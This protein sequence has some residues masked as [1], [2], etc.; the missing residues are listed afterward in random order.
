M[1]KDTQLLQEAYQRISESKH[2][3]KKF[4]RRYNKVTSAL[5]KEVPGSKGYQKLKAERDD[6][7]SILKDHGKTPADLEEMFGKKEIEATEDDN[8]GEP[9]GDD[10]QE[11]ICTQC[12]DSHSLEDCPENCE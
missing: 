11:G 4:A 5:L 10:T 7:V 12:G 8:T 6:L 3:T 9:E 2:I 1:T